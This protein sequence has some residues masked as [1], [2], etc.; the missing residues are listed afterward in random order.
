MNRTYAQT[1]ILKHLYKK[2]TANN[3]PFSSNDTALS[4]VVYGD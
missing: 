4:E 1:F 2:L 3:A